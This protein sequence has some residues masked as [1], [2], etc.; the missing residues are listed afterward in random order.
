MSLGDAEISRTIYRPLSQIESEIRLIKILPSEDP[1][2]PIKCDL[3]HVSLAKPPSYLALSYCWGDQSQ[4]SDIWICSNVMSVTNNLQLALRQM[5]AFGFTSLWVDALCINQE[6][7]EERSAQIVRMPAI[8][9][10]A[11]SV[12]AWLG[13][14]SNGSDK[15]MRM[16]NRLEEGTAL[17]L[18]HYQS[19]GMIASRSELATWDD[20]DHFFA[21][22]YW[23]RLWIIQEIATAS[24]V[25]L[26]CGDRVVEWERMEYLLEQLALEPG[27]AYAEIH[28]IPNLHQIRMDR[29]S[30]RPITLLDCLARSQASQ[31]TDPRDKVFGLLGLAF[32]RSQYVAEPNYKFSESELCQVMTESAIISKRSLDLILLRQPSTALPDLPTWCLDYLHLDTHPFSASMLKYVNGTDTRHRRGVV[33]ARWL[34][35]GNSYATRTSAQF[36]ADG[37]LQCQGWQLGTINGLGRVVGDALTAP[38]PQHDPTLT[39][40]AADTDL[41]PFDAVCRLLLL[42]GMRTS[43][44]DLPAL[45]LALWTPTRQLLAKVTQSDDAAYVKRWLHANG[46]LVLRGRKL[47]DWVVSWRTLYDTPRH[48]TTGLWQWVC[49]V[50]RK[51]FVLFDTTRMNTV[52]TVLR[53][54]MRLCTLTD[55]GVGWAT[56]N[57]RLGDKVFLL[58]GCSVPVVLRHVLGDGRGFHFV[59]HAYVDGV[60]DGAFWAEF[61]QKRLMDV[62]I[63]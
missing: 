49:E 34:T 59:G 10:E 45:L 23:T 32:D 55:D 36:Q 40:D 31:S 15:I 44:S 6:D 43:F 1:N 33:L 47:R 12:V 30:S 2:G 9:K 26:T 21:R 14:A 24:R 25:I 5:R 16:L 63:C 7:R 27:S 37:I 46:A 39:C 38:F 29:M 51:G 57:A 53:E 61:D 17:P 62:F 48:G 41:T 50:A 3:R 54:G 20:L 56:P 28:L 11:S 60:M 18:L 4:R 8:Y 19:S 52:A 42:Y 13:A 22:P 35:T 58:R